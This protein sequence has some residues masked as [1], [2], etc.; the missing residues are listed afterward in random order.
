LGVIAAGVHSAQAQP[1]GVRMAAYLGHQRDLERRQ[2]GAPGLDRLDL[3]AEHGQ[4]LDDLLEPGL[5]LEVLPQP[6]QR[7]LHRDSPP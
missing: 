5:G 3:E 4:P 6:G 1:L 2:I 7:E